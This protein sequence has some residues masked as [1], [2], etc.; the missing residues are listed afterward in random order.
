[1]EVTVQVEDDRL[2]PS[3]DALE[4]ATGQLPADRA[5]G[6][7]AEDVGVQDFDTRDD[8]AHQPGMEVTGECLGFR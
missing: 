2:G 4:Q 3:P 6:Y 8:T 5:G 7:G 1:M